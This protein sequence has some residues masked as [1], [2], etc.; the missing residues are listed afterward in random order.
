MCKWRREETQYLSPG[1]LPHLEVREV[2]MK[3]QKGLERTG[4]TDQEKLEKSGVME[5]KC[6][7]KGDMISH[8]KRY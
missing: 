6:F 4:Q 5:F 2:R 7:K 3:K 8:M 1:T